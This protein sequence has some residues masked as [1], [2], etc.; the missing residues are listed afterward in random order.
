MV[1]IR[2]GQDA[3]W[4]SNHVAMTMLPYCKAEWESGNKAIHKKKKKT[5]LAVL[6]KKN[7]RH[8]IMY[9]DIGSAHL[10]NT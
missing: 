7:S 10:G 2:L 5:T 4:Y 1:F 8:E 6:A 9:L 3:H